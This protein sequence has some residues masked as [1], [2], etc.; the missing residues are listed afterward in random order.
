MFLE[1][2]YL[3]EY[4]LG[5]EGW[6]DLTNE[7]RLDLLIKEFYRLKEQERKG[8]LN[9]GMQEKTIMKVLEYDGYSSYKLKELLIKL[10]DIGSVGEY[11]KR[12]SKQKR[13]M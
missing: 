11:V 5:C 1:Y 2:K 9:L 3:L 6:D 10:G 7:E 13:L 12:N 8:L 4:A